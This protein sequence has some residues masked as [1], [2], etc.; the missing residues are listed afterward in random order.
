MTSLDEV[1]FFNLSHAAWVLYYFNHIIWFI[2]VISNSMFLVVYDKHPFINLLNRVEEK[3]PTIISSWC[4]T[5]SLILI[6]DFVT[7]WC[8]TIL[9]STEELN[10][11]FSSV[12]FGSLPIWILVFKYIYIYIYIYYI[13]I[14]YYI[15]IYYINTYI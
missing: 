10:Y 15:Y 3:S 11:S 8:C 5:W 2:C 13:Y 14:L 6:Y 9:Y 4:H 7:M 1:K 12:D